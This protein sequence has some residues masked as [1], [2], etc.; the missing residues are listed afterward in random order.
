MTIAAA[1][2]HLVAMGYYMCV[3]KLAYKC[4]VLCY[5]VPLRVLV[6]VHNIVQMYLPL[7]QF[8][9]VHDNCWSVS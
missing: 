5:N 4:R 1:V 6:Y 3:S 7:K 8:T 9:P 2:T